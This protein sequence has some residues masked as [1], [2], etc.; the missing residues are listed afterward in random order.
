MATVWRAWDV[1]LHRYVA[2]KLLARV[3]GTDP[4]FIA[5]FERE[6]RHAASLNHP[7]IVT[8]FDFGTDAG[9]SYLIMELVEGESLADLLR[10]VGRLEASRTIAICSGILDGLEIAHQNDIVHRDIKPSNILLGPN[11]VKVADFG[12]ARASG[13]V[14]SLTDTGVLIGTVSYLSPEQCAGASAT[15]RSDIY[16][17]GCLAYQCLTGSPPFTGESAASVMYQHQFFR[18]VPVVERRPNVPES[19]SL[20]IDRALAKDP[21]QRFSDAKEM[22]LAICGSSEPH[23]STALVGL[24]GPD[25]DQTLRIDGTSQIPR[26]LAA[27]SREGRNGKRTMAVVALVAA[28]LAAG[29]VAAGLVASHRDQTPAASV[30]KQS[31]RVISP[32]TTSATSTPPV[33]GTTAPAASVNP[34]LTVNECPSS[35]GLQQTPTSRI[36]STIAAFLPA[37]EADR[38]A[39]YSDSTRSVDP[40]LAPVGWDCSVS[41][42]ADGS[43]IVSVFPS[44]QPDPKVLGGT[45]PATTQGVI[46]YS[47]SAC[48]GC[49]ADLVCPVFS[50][51]ETQLGYSGQSC[52]SEPP[53]E[54]VTFLA[55]SSTSDHGTVALK[56][57]PG[58]QGTVQM[59]GGDYEAIGVM[60][61]T[62]Q[63][64]EGQAAAES[65]VLQQD[66][67]ALCAAITNDFLD[68]AWG[69]DS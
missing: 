32:A 27:A 20:A 11:L 51:S 61:Y 54:Q 2:V 26:R 3:L 18:P 9:L 36:P 45:L 57:P 58:V 15:T 59:S 6:A 25:T 65:C 19:L 35:Y 16:A 43:T 48:Q 29:G 42:G 53:A 69:F 37:S 7:N 40:V 55:G 31:G 8:I 44:G 28:L 60:R 12:I 21:L 24:H 4:G 64:N 10:R 56:D 50:N 66:E 49:V 22:Q 13:E 34:T 63:Q 68:R 33:P 41:V 47:P 67:S 23:G 17:V 1:R 62:D 38:L 30:R 14:T 52:D 5:R 39:F 46:A